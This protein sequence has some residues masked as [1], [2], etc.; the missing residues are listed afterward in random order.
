MGTGAAQAG[1]LILDPELFTFETRQDCLVRER[2]MQLDVDLLLETGML[3]AEA[4]HV[5]LHGHAF[6]ILRLWIP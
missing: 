1:D 4:F 6:D 3:A 5:I 2:P